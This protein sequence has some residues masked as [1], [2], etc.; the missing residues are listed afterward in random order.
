MATKSNLPRAEIGKQTP[1]LFNRIRTTIETAFYRNNVVK[2][3][4]ISYAYELATQANGT[5]ITDL[6][7]YRAGDLGLPN[8]AKVLIFND[9]II[10]G[11]Q[12]KARQLVNVKDDGDT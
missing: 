2:V 10:T 11:R 6:D 1:Q 3:T 5:I 4:S 9:G 7:V 8:D 12:A